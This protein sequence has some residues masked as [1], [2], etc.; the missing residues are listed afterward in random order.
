[1][2]VFNVHDSETVVVVA[3]NPTLPACVSVRGPYP[4]NVI[5]AWPWS[6]SDEPEGMRDEKVR[7]LEA[8]VKHVGPTDEMGPT[9]TR[10]DVG[11]FWVGGTGVAHP[12][13]LNECMSPWCHA[14][15]P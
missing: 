2:R 7:E 12:H 9:G 15:A 3:T 6:W 5:W 13:P 10:L 11:F 14:P 8:M 4:V 1:M